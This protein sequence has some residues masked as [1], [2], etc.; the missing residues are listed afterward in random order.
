MIKQILNGYNSINTA[1]EVDDYPWGFRLRTKI[2]YWIE[3][4]KGKGDRFC[5]RTIDPRNGRKCTPKCSTYSTFMFMYLD[6]NGH[7]K[8]DVI[9]AYHKEQFLDKFRFI[10]EEIGAVHLNDIQKENL[11]H[12]YYM[13]WR[14]SYPYHKVKYSPE[15]QP[16]YTQFMNDL[17]KHIRECDFTKLIVHDDPPAEDNPEGEIKMTITTSQSVSSNE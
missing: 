14:Y 7:V 1:Y 8:H 4:K 15:M 13:H 6:E 3:T 12:N 9:D 5:S 16:V 2:Y 17:L 11:R 10:I